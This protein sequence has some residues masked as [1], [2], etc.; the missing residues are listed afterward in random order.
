MTLEPLTYSAA[1]AAHLLGISERHV[2]ELVARGV[3]PVLELGRRKVIPRKAIELVIDRAIE[4]FDPD[5]LLSTLAGAARPSD[6]GS[7]AGVE[8]RPGPAGSEALSAPRRLGRDP[9]GSS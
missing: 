2:Y 9:V 6:S 7:A 8:G 3:L 1:D 5:A 4:G